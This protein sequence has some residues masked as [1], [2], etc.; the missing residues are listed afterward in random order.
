LTPPE[1]LLQQ[2]RMILATELG[3]DPLLRKDIRERFKLDGLVTVVPTEKGLTKIDDH[4]PYNVCLNSLFMFDF[5]SKSFVH[6]ISSIFVA[7]QSSS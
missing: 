5:G 2:A 7:N 4:H 3:K 6:S 1:L